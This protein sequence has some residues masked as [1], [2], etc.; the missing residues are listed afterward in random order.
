MVGRLGDIGDGG[1][2]LRVIVAHS[3]VAVEES[4]HF[5]FDRL[6]SVQSTLSHLITT[7]VSRAMFTHFSWSIDDLNTIYIE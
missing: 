4:C 5:L 3:D 1:A 2:V 7:S 6:K